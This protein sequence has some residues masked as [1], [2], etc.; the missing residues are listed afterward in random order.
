MFRRKI[1]TVLIGLVVLLCGGVDA[2][3]LWLETGHHVWTDESPY[4]TEVFLKDDVSLEFL[5]GSMGQLSTWDRSVATLDGGQTPGLWM[6]TESVVH[7]HSGELGYVSAADSSVLFLYAYDVVYDPLGGIS[8]QGYVEGFFYENDDP[9]SF[10]F[11]NPQSWE[12]VRIVPEPGTLVL[13]SLG[14]VMI[15]QRK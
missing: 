8:N 13:L 6:S 15:R 10:S 4:Y 9:F 7:F 3:I 5:G 14:V 12:H 11:G 2:Q 1:F